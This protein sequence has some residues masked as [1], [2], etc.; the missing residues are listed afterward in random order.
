MYIN[1]IKF[2]FLSFCHLKAWSI[3]IM[4]EDRP[5]RNPNGG[6][7][8]QMGRDRGLLQAIE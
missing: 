4:A 1:G 5:D 7:Y 2:Q 6:W 8:P 3:S